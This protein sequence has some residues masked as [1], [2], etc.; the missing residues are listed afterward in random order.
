MNA[1]LR[2]QFLLDRDWRFLNHG[3]FGACPRPVFEKYQDWQRELESQ[4]VH[5]MSR[6]LPGLLNDARERLAQYINAP[7]DRLIFAT[8]ATSALNLFIRSIPWQPGDE[9]LS[10]D[11]EYGALLRTW[12]YI[13]QTRDVVFRPLTI[14]VDYQDENEFVDRIWREVT[15]RTRAIFLSHITSPTAMLFPLQTLIQRA[16]AANILTII[17]G[18]HA[19]GL[20]PLDLLS[21]D[22]DAYAGNCHKWLCAPKGSAFL[23]V[24][25]S[26]H[27]C[28]VPLVISHGWEEGVNFVHSNQW[29][30]TQDFAAYLSIPAALDFLAANE[31]QTIRTQCVQMAEAAREHLAAHG[32]APIRKLQHRLNIQMFA[33]QLPPCE[34]SQVYETLWKDYR[35]EVPILRWQDRLLVRV[36]IQ[37]YNTAEDWLALSQA[38]SQIMS[39]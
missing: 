21:L 28:M 23:Y 29:Y 6:R 32:F 4:P 17:D 22:P 19:P 10:S 26:L 11:Q 25:P 36:S 35:I 1:E 39:L 38:L 30:G 16:R 18:A 9:I 31:W 20:L 12:E 3:S 14:P 27:E 24:H 33:S 7:P 34:P 5:F 13:S 2:E 37:A 8:N 15:P